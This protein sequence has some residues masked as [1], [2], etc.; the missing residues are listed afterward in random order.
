VVGVS[1]LVRRFLI[2]VVDHRRVA[3]LGDIS[4]A[5][6]TVMDERLGVVRADVSSARDLTPAQRTEVI[7]ELARITGKNARARFSI[8]E[9]LIGGVTARIG[10]TVYDGSVRGQLEVLRQQLAGE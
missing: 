8:Q 5:F 9:D 4:E 7:A 1:D 6:E 3:L 10:S 2:V